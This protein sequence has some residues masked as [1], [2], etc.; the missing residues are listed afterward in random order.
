MGNDKF[1]DKAVELNGHLKQLKK[2]YF[3]RPYKN[4][5]S[6]KHQ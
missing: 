2:T 5:L 1:N 6:E 4:V 3:D